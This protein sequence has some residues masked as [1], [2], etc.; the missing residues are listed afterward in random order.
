MQFDPE[1][2]NTIFSWIQKNEDSVHVVAELAEI[3][4]RFVFHLK[5]Y[6]DTRQE[7]DLVIDFNDDYS[8]F[9]IY[10]FMDGIL[11]EHRKAQMI[12]EALQPSVYKK[13]APITG[14]PSGKIIINDKQPQKKWKMSPINNLTIFDQYND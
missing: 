11:S 3:P 9:R 8:K 6:I 10:E 4:E 7:M 14:A 2:Y 1:Y 5:H 13:P 12:H